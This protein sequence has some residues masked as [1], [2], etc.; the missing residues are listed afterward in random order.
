M[1]RV[2]LIEDNPDD[3]ALTELLLARSEGAWECEVVASVRAAVERLRRGGIDVI[4]LDLGLPDSV[5]S[6]A[7]REILAASPAVPALVMTGHVDDV[8]AQSA[9]QAGAKGCFAKGTLDGPALGRV[10][11]EAMQP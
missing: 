3:A 1:S 4:L 5:G 2:L 8:R 10:L 6:S 11:L 9:L 7:V